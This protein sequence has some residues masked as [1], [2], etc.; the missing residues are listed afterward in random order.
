MKG[1]GSPASLRLVLLAT[2]P[3]LGSCEAPDPELVPDAVLQ[4][5]LGLTPDDRVH[6][7]RISTGVAERADPASVTV[8]PG[9]YVQFVSSDFLVHEVSFVLDS[10][11]APA[12]AFLERTGQRASPP[13]LEQDARFVVS[14]VAAP[15]GRY[16][17]ALSGNRAPGNGEIVVD[18]LAS[19]RRFP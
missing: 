18:S 14:F 4:S 13:L 8:E 3:L 6:T 2:A 1:A 11:D 10:L 7:V 5:Q 16:P 17:Y 19:N 15:P 9:E 12:R